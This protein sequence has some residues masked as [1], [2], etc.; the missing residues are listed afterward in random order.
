[1]MWHRLTGAYVATRCAK[2]AEHIATYFRIPSINFVTFLGFV[3]IA[4]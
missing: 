4:L 1:M 3:D 2:G